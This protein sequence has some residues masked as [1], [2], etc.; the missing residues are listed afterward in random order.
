[1]VLQQ[2]AKAV[3]MGTVVL[4][5]GWGS[6]GKGARISDL[7]V[8]LDPRLYAVHTT[9]DPV[10]YE[11]RMPFMARFWSRLGAHGTMTIF[12][13][14][15]YD[16]L[17][18]AY[19]EEV[20]HGDSVPGLDRDAR[21][22]LR[23]RAQHRISRHI[24][25]ARAFER[26]IQADGYLMVRFFLHI[27]A[28]EQRRRAVELM[29]D[30]NTA[31]KVDERD[32]SQMQHYD[33]YYEAFDDWLERA[34]KSGDTWH[35]VPALHKRNAN[36][37]IMQ[38]LADEMTAALEARGFDTSQPIPA[39]DVAHEYRPPVS[40]EPPAKE[41]T[42][43]ASADI[44]TRA[45]VD[46]EGA[47]TPARVLDSS[48]RLTV[49]AD[50]GSGS[51]G[52]AGDF[53]APAS[54][55]VVAATVGEAARSS[56][57]AAVG[58]AGTGETSDDLAVL[59]ADFSGGAGLADAT[60]S[61]SSGELAGIAG[62][63][64]D[65]RSAGAEDAGAFGPADADG[66][67]ADSEP[68]LDADDLLAAIAAVTL[69]TPV[70]P[71][72]GATLA[73][74]M[75]GGSLDAIAS[76]A[77]A[78]AD[79]LITPTVGT[80]AGVGPDAGTGAPG[81]RRPKDVIGS[82]K[83][84]TSRFNLVKVPSL[85]DVGYDKTL[86]DADYS[87]QLKEEQ[88]TLAELSLALYRSRIPLI[89]AYE[90]WDAAGKGGNIKRVAAALDARSYV[91][92]PIAAPTHD[93]LAHPFLWRFWNDLPR[94]G[95]T[96]IFDRTWYGRVLVERIEGFARPEE[97]RR[98]FEEINEFEDDLRTWGAVL[99]KFWI[100]VSPDE[101]LRRFRDRQNDP[102][103]RWKITDED[104]RNREKND[105]YRRCVNDMLRLTSTEYAPWTVV[106]SDDKHYA[107]VKAL[108][109]INKAIRRR[110]KE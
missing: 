66:Q 107:R 58:E 64:S 103:R 93:E 74:A 57:L 98:A 53:V 77:P 22:A 84:L 72:L 24:A 62:H 19:I 79:G 110:L 56:G 92:H 50:C 36:L 17:T 94:T 4:F 44:P 30:R 59:L 54:G 26:Q 61:T 9:E 73:A 23:Q 20:R 28:E 39:G 109:V 11:S 35:V 70:D 38:A 60:G 29:L 1:M 45:E 81:H 102:T 67:A 5:E 87:R 47:Y 25:S 82:A 96:A 41:G 78:G 8:N 16:A 18:R 85:D 6:S 48:I 55:F 108:K 13:Q 104:W 63:V 12:D 106:E 21:A 89:I 99:V 37:Q 49:D 14:A 95:H 83:H 42:A 43:P 40:S 31:W 7:V 91:V 68:T 69:G 76:E 71:E 75:P 52:A 51:G 32:I 80:G 27:T 2:Q 101:Q 100:D 33:E 88:A 65:A 105:L 34:T 90:G 46:V 10:G 15:Y 3:G 97:W 86:A